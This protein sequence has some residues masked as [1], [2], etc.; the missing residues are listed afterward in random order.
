IAKTLG[1]KE[2]ASTLRA[3]GKNQKYDD[4]LLY[5]LHSGFD[6]PRPLLQLRELRVIGEVE[7][8]RR[9]GDEAI[10][11]GLDIAAD[12]G[13]GAKKLGARPEVGTAARVDAPVELLGVRRHVLRQHFHP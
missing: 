5:L 2:V 1:N 11:E 12:A 10:V 8:Q 4:V 6:L 9:D 3:E 13:I 7:L